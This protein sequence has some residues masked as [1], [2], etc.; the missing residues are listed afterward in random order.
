[1]FSRYRR[2]PPSS[3]NSPAA[4]RKRGNKNNS[5]Q[6]PVVALAELRS[7]LN[8][9]DEL[10]ESFQ[11]VGSE[12]LT[13]LSD[14]TNRESKDGITEQNTDG[15]KPTDTAVD[16]DALSEASSSEKEATEKATTY[17]R[18]PSATAN[19]LLLE[20]NA[21][22]LSISE[23]EEEEMVELIRRV[24]ELVVLSERMAGQILEGSSNRRDGSRSNRGDHDT[25]DIDEKS[26]N[27]EDAMPYLALF[28]LFCERN[29]LANIVN[30]V[31]GVAFAPQEKRQSRPRS[32][33]SLDKMQLNRNS[34][35]VQTPHI[36]PPLTIA[37]QGIQ[38]VS[39]LI[40]NVSR[41]TSLYFL[42]SN[43]RV[44]DL[45]GLPIHLYKRAEMNH[46]HYLRFARRGSRRPTT[47]SGLPLPVPPTSNS[48]TNYMSN[49]IGELTTHFVSFLKSLAMRVNPE[50]LQFFL[51]FPAIEESSE[52]ERSVAEKQTLQDGESF[53]RPICSDKVPLI[54]TKDS[55]DDEDTM[56]EHLVSKLIRMES[57]AVNSISEEPTETDVSGALH[58]AAD[59]LMATTLAEVSASSPEGALNSSSVSS[60]RISESEQQPDV[61]FPLYARALEFCSSEQDS[62]VRV[63]AM[64]ICMNMIRLAT[65]CHDSV[66]SN[67]DI[68][69]DKRRDNLNA[70]DSNDHDSE[71][72]SVPLPTT[73]TP[74]GMLHEAPSLPIQDRV[75]I[76]KY[77]CDP[78]RV[79]DLVSPLCAR[80]T[81]QFGQVEGTVRNLQELANAS[82]PK[83]L[84]LSK[85][86]RKTRL[87]NSIHDLVANLQDEL[88]MF[89]DLL[90]VGL[91]SLNEQAIEMLLATFIYPMLLQPLLL[92]L[93]RFSSSNT[94]EQ[95]RE[96]GKSVSS[97][98]QN[99]SNDSKPAIDLQ[100]PPP[101]VNNS[102]D[103]T[104]EDIISEDTLRVN[105][106]HFPP[107]QNK[108]LKTYSSENVDLA[109][110]KTALFG[111]SVIFQ[112]IS[113]P[114][115]KH[116]I[117][118]ALLHPYSPPASGGSVIQIPPRI[119][120]FASYRN[121]VSDII[122]LERNHHFEF[123]SGIPLHIY[124]FG[125]RLQQHEEI[126]DENKPNNDGLC[127]FI[128]APALIETFLK[129]TG[130][131]MNKEE[132][133]DRINPYRKILLSYISGSGEMVALQ[134][135]ATMAMHDVV[136]G[137]DYGILRKNLLS[138][139]QY[140][141]S[142]L[143]CLC[144]NIVNKSVTLDGWWKVSFNRVAAKTLLDVI[145]AD[146]HYLSCAYDA[147]TEMRL[148]AATF[149]LSLPSR[150]DE[151]SRVSSTKTNGKSNSV[152]KQHL[153]TWLLDRF[154]FDQPN[155]S[156]RS[157]V[158][159]ICN[160][161]GGYCG[162]EIIGTQSVNDASDLLCE[163]SRLVEN[164]LVSETKGNTPFHC[165]ATWA[166][167]CLSLDGFCMKIYELKTSTGTPSEKEAATTQLSRSRS[168]DT[169]ITSDA[170]ANMSPKLVAALQDKSDNLEDSPK[171]SSVAPE[172]GSIV[173]LVGK[174]AF[175][176]VCEVTPSFASLF[177]GRTCVS[178][179]GVQWQSLYLVVIGKYAVLAEP[180]RS[181]IGGEGR[182]I[183]T[184]KLSC[185]AAKKDTAVLANNST[186]ARRL[187]LQ[188]S[189]IDRK[190][191]A[192]FVLESSSSDKKPSYGPEKLSL[193]RS[194]VDLWFEDS[195]ACSVAWK[196]LAGKIAKA[197]AK[198]GSKIKAALLESDSF[199]SPRQA[200]M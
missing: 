88:L 8:R 70:N 126:A 25:D 113:N 186:P 83:H 157:V 156:S 161:D 93:H 173:G 128:L 160:L 28:E 63:T 13:A 147:I 191:P 183:T 151:K 74:S 184:C 34:E 131:S 5:N 19:D 112:S 11:G 50:T 171:K 175:P 197:R 29:A 109:P 105:S 36:L 20:S 15:N 188:H 135:L 139:R 77:A 89:D 84:Q 99:S 141:K 10:T 119:T 90:R 9:L 71:R 92:P 162:M 96:D 98:N 193:T 124:D 61:E 2:T 86:E 67:M 30:I 110:S 180:E 125:M 152:D 21:H 129:L 106:S 114:C 169:D 143:D 57:G 100:S 49:E 59:S 187:L 51:T 78:R 16:K 47:Y 72:N 200:E 87:T 101:F 138:D 194:R 26:N 118:A 127:T 168:D 155:K 85:A 154:Y 6:N 136:S 199:P 64:N 58:S 181:G 60:N 65:V 94:E 149:L 153:E 145:K 18:S 103:S 27:S 80:L 17:R 22:F 134:K 133:V 39:I 198:R 12:L 54:E 68:D 33:S 79:S 44:N 140:S 137:V 95:E 107:N 75:A 108:L 123:G 182:V 111:I 69:R 66:E 37:T 170:I 178:N 56:S 146:H 189:S 144:H 73:I 116:L 117:L 177:T 97:S 158:E 167:A 122:R 165:A 14:G 172:H 1:M 115:L 142:I 132:A 163:D 104:C 3:A 53:S 38:S 195:N 192:L 150:L 46:A 166:L 42:L 31:T 179:E 159:N 82:I 164:M 196:A 120:F 4:N 62:F 121:Q 102:I 43:N 55:T 190:P 40:Q 24:A 52:S 23:K 48:L 76:A 185:L 130:S 7:A 91:V 35:A 148:E 32:S 81:S 176:C 174:A 45:I 41:A